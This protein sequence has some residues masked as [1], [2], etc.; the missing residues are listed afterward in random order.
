MPTQAKPAASEPPYGAALLICVASLLLLML[1][2]GGLPKSVAM[3]AGFLVYPLIPAVINFAIFHRSSWHQ[4]FRPARRTVLLVLLDVALCIGVMIG[5]MV[6]YAMVAWTFRD[7]MKFH[8]GYRHGPPVYDASTVVQ[9]VV[10][11]ALVTG[12]TAFLAVRKNLLTIPQTRLGMILLPF[13]AYTAVAFIA[14][15]VWN[16][17]FHRHDPV[18]NGDYVLA[19]SYLVSFAVLTVGGLIQRRKESR[20]TGLATFGFAIA[21]LIFMILLA[22]QSVCAGHNDNIF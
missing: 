7:Q 21:A 19:F 4:E 18:A 22:L 1:V 14:L 6:I 11:V 15:N 13:K 16:A 10:L 12:T 5:F 3:W 17:Y 9:Y 2:N 20:P 8:N